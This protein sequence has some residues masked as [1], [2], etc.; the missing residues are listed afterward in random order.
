LSETQ[1]NVNRG[2][3][4]RNAAKGG[5]VLAGSGGVLASV[6]GVAFAAGPTKSD[7]TTLQAAYT[8]ESLAVFIYSAILK[9]FGAFKHPKLENK[10]YFVAALKNEK[11]HK[12]FLASAL[13]S[14]TPTGLRFKVPA[15]VTESGQA[16]LNTGVALETAFVEAYLG[17]AH[18]LS[19]PDLRLVAAR[20]A[21][22]EA[23]HF[24]FFDAAAGGHGVLPSLP[25]TDTIPHTVHKLQPFLA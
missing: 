1:T 12:A 15:S 18:T 22:N 10:D 6:Q 23:T 2:Q 20:V 17:A 13:G 14:K 4:L 21:A 19:S 16:L 24:S 7:I 9:N 25:K 3:F 8:A 5:I 11:D